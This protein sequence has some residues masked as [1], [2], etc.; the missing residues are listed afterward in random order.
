MQ[1]IFS[2]VL[3]QSYTYTSC[4]RYGP[5]CFWSFFWH[6]QNEIRKYICLPMEAY[7]SPGRMS[8]VNWPY[9]VRAVSDSKDTCSERICPCKKCLH[10]W[11]FFIMIL[12]FLYMGSLFSTVDYSHQWAYYGGIKLLFS[13]WSLVLSHDSSMR[14][15]V[16]DIVP[17]LI[18]F[19]FNNAFNGV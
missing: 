13:C 7:L 16:H 4:F 10:T 17:C 9:S 15:L 12:D 11:F 6:L 8:E 19:A 3:F 5:S 2:I 18:M 14:L 1:N